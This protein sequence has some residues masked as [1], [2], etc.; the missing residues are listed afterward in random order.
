M[1]AAGL[2]PI[3]TVVDSRAVMI[4]SKR[5]SNAKLIDLIV[6]RVRGV[7]SAQKYVLCS[8]NV[9]RSLLA[10]TVNITPG[11][12]AA[13]VTALDDP[14]WAAVSSMVEKAIIAVVMDQ[15]TEAGAT[16]ILVLNIENT[17]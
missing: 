15:L 12:R 4:K 11:K 3:D 2:K 8:Y 14:D 9:P 5:A 16:D 1:R 10:A 6:S 7:I 17:R 13:T